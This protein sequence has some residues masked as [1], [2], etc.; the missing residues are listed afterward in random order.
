MNYSGWLRMNAN[1]YYQLKS[2]VCSCP[3]NSWQ[4]FT[5]SESAKETPEQGDVVN[6]TPK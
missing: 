2:N 4:T 5:F 1:S 3:V 6:V